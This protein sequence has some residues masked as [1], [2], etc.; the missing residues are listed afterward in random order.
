MSIYPAR[1]S[2][3]TARFGLP[4]TLL[5]RVR[6]GVSSIGMRSYFSCH[7]CQP[8]KTQ[9]CRVWSVE[10][11]VIVNQLWQT[12]PHPSALRLPPPQIMNRKLKRATAFVLVFFFVEIVGGLW[13]GSL[14]IISDAAH[15]LTDVSVSNF[16]SPLISSIR[17]CMYWLKCTTYWS[18]SGK[19][20]RAK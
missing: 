17:D 11:V 5:Y 3:L 2:S 9:N 15:L 7:V 1:A 20:F 6:Y 12:P 10:R 13:S 18:S 8:P 4:V 16:H 19:S 14:A